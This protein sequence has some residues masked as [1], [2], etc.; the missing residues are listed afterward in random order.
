MTGIMDVGGGL[1][2]VYSAGIYDYLLDN[3]IHMD[4]CIGVS[5][6]SANLI[7][8]VAGQNKRNYKFYMDY[9]FRKEYMSLENVF[10][11]GS[12]LSLEYI[13]SVLCNHDGENP[14]DYKSFS[15]NPCDYV[16]VATNA[17]SGKPHYF[18]KKDVSQDN[19][20]IL[21]ASCSIP[22]V[23]KPYNINNTFYFDGG[24]SDPMPYEK[25]FSDGCDKLIAV[26]T[27]PLDYVK[28]PQK[29]MRFINRG[30]KNYPEIARLISVR[31]EKYNNAVSELL[32]LQ[33][34]GKVLILAPESCYGM[35][36]LSRDRDAFEK[37]YALGYK[38]AE[39]IKDFI[40]QKNSS[41]AV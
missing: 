22:V 20:N 40:S 16:V 25:A 9:A 8:Y 30:L 24:V 18:T 2:D 39:T 31:H 1:R 37:I 21:K 4:Y 34:Q 12:Y 32:E 17:Q 38:D 6:G 23:C 29:L 41:S 15:D 36:T 13:Y 35:S 3:N 33:K 27:R 19:Y 7:S 28:P 11:C 5:A 10:K 26:L 14:I